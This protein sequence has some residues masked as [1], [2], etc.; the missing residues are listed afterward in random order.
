MRHRL[1]VSSRSLLMSFVRTVATLEL[2]RLSIHSLTTM[3]VGAAARNVSI[4]TSL[5]F[6]GNEDS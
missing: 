6:L 4:L 3:C 5:N 1:G 2:L